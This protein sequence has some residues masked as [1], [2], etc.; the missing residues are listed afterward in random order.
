MSQIEVFAEIVCPFTHVGL[1]R[2]I[3]ARDASG[4]EA[5]VR[6]HAWPLE[7]INGSPQDPDLV[8]REIDALRADVA[9]ELF[10]G[11]D[12]ARL[13]RTSIAAFGLAAVAYEHHGVGVGEA[14][15]LAL[16]RRRVRGRARCRRS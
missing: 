5:P 3:D 8:A 10:R 16:A 15:S 7:L 12:R 14:V 11:F 13:P 2:L 1:R 9:P 6:V 4:A